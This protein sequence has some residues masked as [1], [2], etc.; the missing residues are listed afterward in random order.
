SR[1]L[2][3]ECAHRLDP[4]ASAETLAAT[5][6]EL[7][8]DAERRARMIDAACQY[9]TTNSFRAAAGR[10]FDEVIAPELA[11]PVD[12]RERQLVGHGPRVPRCPLPRS[13]DRLPTPIPRPTGRAV[14]CGPPRA[15]CVPV[16]SSPR[17]RA[18]AC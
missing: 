10:L 6:A 12:R 18:A 3:P 2:P 15:R 13:P 4:A 5:I 7:L 9:A 17:R 1:E 11:R 16:H 8:G 14:R